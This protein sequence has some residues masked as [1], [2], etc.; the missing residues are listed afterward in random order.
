M[1]YYAQQIAYNFVYVSILLYTQKI[2]TTAE[3]SPRQK[4]RLL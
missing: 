2:V 1:L 4:T 3:L